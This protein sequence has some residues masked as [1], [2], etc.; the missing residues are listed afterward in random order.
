VGGLVGGL[1]GV[2][3][4]VFVLVWVCVCV[5]V[6]VRVCVFLSSQILGCPLGVL[7]DVLA[8]S[9]HCGTLIEISLTG[10]DS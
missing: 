7:R 6:R 10:K 8:P 3:L 1:V 9:C 4:F 2:F 5:C